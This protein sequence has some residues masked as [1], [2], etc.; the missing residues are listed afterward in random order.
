[1]TPNSS[2]IAVDGGLNVCQSA[3]DLIT[4][5]FDSANC[6]DD[7]PDVPKLY[8]E[9]Q[10]KTDLEKALDY[11]FT[12]PVEKI[13]I[14]GACGKRLDHTLTNILLLTRYPKIISFKTATETVFALSTEDVF[15]CKKGQT[16][17]LIPI[18]GPVTSITTKGLKWELEEGE[19]SREFIGISNIAMQNEVS[20]SF[21]SG[22]LIC[23]LID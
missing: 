5:D 20:L 21:K 16:L 6:L 14:L 19:L 7:F 13:T 2:L 8:T 15:H 12:F 9:D 1:M 11:L 18:N 4:G 17:S 23:C 3:P 22:D 10:N